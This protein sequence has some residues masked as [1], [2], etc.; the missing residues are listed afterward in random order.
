MSWQKFLKEYSIIN[1]QCY[2]K[3]E[4]KLLR[5]ALQGAH[6]NFGMNHPSTFFAVAHLSEFCW[7]YGKFDDAETLLRHSLSMSRIIRDT[8]S[9]GGPV[10]GTRFDHFTGT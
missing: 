10:F 9:P 6:I 3:E 5:W 1:Q 8:L 7:R 4:E 2:L